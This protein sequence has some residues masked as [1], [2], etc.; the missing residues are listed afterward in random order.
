MAKTINFNDISFNKLNILLCVAFL[1]TALFSLE[2]N[3]HSFSTGLIGLSRVKASGSLDSIGFGHLGLS[4]SILSICLLRSQR[5]NIC[6]VLFFLVSIFGLFILF[7]G[8]SRGPVVAFITLLLIYIIVRKKYFAFVFLLIF[9]FLFCANYGEIKTLF[10]SIGSLGLGRVFDPIMGYSPFSVDVTSGR[11]SIYE[12]GL[13]SFFSNPLTGSGFVL[14]DGR[15]VHNSVLESFM[16][17]GIVGGILFLCV[18]CYVIFNILKCLSVPSR[19]VRPYDF[20]YYLF[21]QYT[22]Y[23][24]FSRELLTLSLFWLTLFLSAKLLLHENNAMNSYD[25]LFDGD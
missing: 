20:V 18:V 14:N 4:L 15:Y 24:L 8:G 3:I 12:L 7:Y 17:T 2:N 22:V 11:S 1:I 21:I 23:S 5:N 13:D 19:G 25:C 9:I 6:K 16:A 10:E